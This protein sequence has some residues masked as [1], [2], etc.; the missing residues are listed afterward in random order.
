MNNSMNILDKTAPV[1]LRSGVGHTPAPQIRSCPCAYLS[2]Q[3]ADPN[4]GHKQNKRQGTLT[5]R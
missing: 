3:T 4:T 2:E 5:P 1:E